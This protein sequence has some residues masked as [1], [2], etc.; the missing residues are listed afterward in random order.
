MT[1][2]LTDEIICCNLPH[3]EALIRINDQ[4]EKGKQLQIN[5]TTLKTLESIKSDFTKWHAFSV[6]LLRV[7]FSSNKLSLEFINAA[8]SSV[9]YIDD[10][11]A[12]I[13]V[14]KKRLKRGLTVLESIAERIGF[15]P[16]KTVNVTS[17]ANQP[18]DYIDIITTQFHQVAC[19]LRHRYSKRSTIIIEDEYDV[20]DTLHS[21]FKLFFEDIRPEEYTPSYAGGSARCDFL[22]KT[23]KIMVEVK[24][25][26]VGLRDKEI[27][28]QL[29]EDILRYQA[30]PD[31]D[32]LYCFVYDPK[33]IITNPRGLENDLSKTYNNLTVKVVIRPN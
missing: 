19:Q 21:L 1:K 6:D 4:I 32:Y 33:S 3:D 29:A 13:G 23:E 7:I 8:R 17:Y 30:H 9:A 12:E 22:L 24:M 11:F 25:T 10:P 26:R 20:Q 2:S 15:Y 31:C 14:Y 18:I 28:N 27:G 16:V 5:E